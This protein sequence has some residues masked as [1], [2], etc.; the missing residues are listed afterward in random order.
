MAS[1][2]PRWPGLAV[3][4]P[5]RPPAASG[6]RGR[7]ARLLVAHPVAWPDRA[8]WTG[9]LG[10]AVRRDSRRGRLSGPHR[11]WAPLLDRARVAADR[12][13]IGGHRRGLACAG[14][15]MLPQKRRRWSASARADCDGRRCRCRRKSAPATC[16]HRGSIAPGPEPP[17]P[18]ARQH[19]SGHDP[20]KPRHHRPPSPPPADRQRLLAAAHCPKFLAEKRMRPRCPALPRGFRPQFSR[21]A[22]PFRTEF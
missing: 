5:D 15:I 13:Q 6:E 16:R 11:R 22:L 3:A 12:R 9:P 17:P 14:G 18:S 7:S 8:R 10:A 4:W 1:P 20:A 2:E 21:S 19:Q